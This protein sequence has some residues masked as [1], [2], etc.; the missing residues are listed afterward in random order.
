M[1]NLRFEKPN[2]SRIWLSI[3]WGDV[4]RAKTA[5]GKWGRRATLPA[6]RSTAPRFSC[7]TIAKR[8]R[9]GRTDQRVLQNFTRLNC[10]WTENELRVLDCVQCSKVC[11]VMTI[12]WNSRPPCLLDA[13]WCQR[14][15]NRRTGLSRRSSSLR[16]SWCQPPPTP[17]RCWSS[18]GAPGWGPFQIGEYATPSV[19]L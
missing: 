8:E 10:S 14:G 13:R 7:H 11:T 12:E 2:Q 15:W 18:A 19:S 1:G 9:R 4:C 16:C 5:T 6:E 17:W 3:A